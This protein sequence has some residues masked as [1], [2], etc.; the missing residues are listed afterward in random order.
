MGVASSFIKERR[1]VVKARPSKFFV[2]RAL[3]TE[4]MTRVRCRWP[5]KK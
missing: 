4:N 3:C 2:A 5:G 1:G